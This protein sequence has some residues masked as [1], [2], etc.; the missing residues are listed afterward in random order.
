[1]CC[2][3]GTSPKVLVSKSAFASNVG[4]YTD[5]TDGNFST[6]FTS[7]VKPYVVNTGVTYA[8]LTRWL[9]TTLD[10]RLTDTNGCHRPT[11]TNGVGSD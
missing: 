9:Q 2:R 11:V 8:L 5:A 6:T 1:M 10:L 3:F 7:W 4:Q